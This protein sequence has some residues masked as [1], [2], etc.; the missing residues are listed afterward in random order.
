MLNLNDNY[1]PYAIDAFGKIVSISDVPE[2]KRGLVCDCY[3][4]KCHERLVAKLGYGGKIKHFSHNAN[5]KCLGAAMTLLHLLSEEI[6]MREKSVMAP[7]YKTISETKLTFTQVEVEKRND[8]SDMQPDV[9]G[10]T[11]DGHRWHIEIKNTSGVD[12]CKIVKIRESE[13]ACLEIDVS[14]Q[15]LDK[16]KLTAFLLESTESRKWINNPIYE[17]RIRY[18]HYGGE[19]KQIEK[20]NLY[21][22]EKRFDIIELNKCGY[23]CGVNLYH[24]NCIYLKDELCLNNVEYVICDRI[25]REND[26]KYESPIEVI[27]KTVLQVHYLKFCYEGQSIDR[28][29]ELL[30]EEQIIYFEDGLYGKILKCEKELKGN[31]LVCLCKCNDRIYPLQI[32][33]IW[34]SN[35]KLCYEIVSCNKEKDLNLVKRNYSRAKVCIDNKIVDQIFE[36]M[37]RNN[38]DNIFVERDDCPF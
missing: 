2:N 21:K 29:C 36:K 23:S 33:S 20:F 16:E 1:L 5:R 22:N 31:G 10:V 8:R 11:E 28:I 25:R 6:L 9:V 37:K 19:A 32:F 17:K 24:G 38:Q 7:K 4:P 13:I 34:I 30:L 3:C 14:G 27:D 15:P 26:K 18:E 12:D 35:N